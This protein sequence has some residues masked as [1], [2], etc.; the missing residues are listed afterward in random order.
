MHKKNQLKVKIDSMLIAV[1]RKINEL[2]KKIPFVNLLEV[3][4]VPDC[5]NKNNR[6]MELKT[7]RYDWMELNG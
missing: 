5:L 4:I 6:K 2:E 1:R 3:V 7:F